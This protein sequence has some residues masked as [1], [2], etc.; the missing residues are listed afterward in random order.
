M[1]DLLH[2]SEQI[3]LANEKIFHLPVFGFFSGLK[4]FGFFRI[5]KTISHRKENAAVSYPL[6]KESA[7]SGNLLIHFGNLFIQDS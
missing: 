3:N 2:S 7:V 6:W 5:K 4:F 1:T